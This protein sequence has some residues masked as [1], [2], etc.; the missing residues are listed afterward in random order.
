[1]QAVI[2]VGGKATRLLPLTCNTPKSMV[3]VLNTPFLEHVIT[4]LARHGI[5]EIVLAQGHLAQPIEDYFGDGSRFGVTLSYAVE[6]SPRGTAGAVKNAERYINDTFLVLN[7]DIFTDLDISALLDFHRA[8]R[9][10]I[11]I[12]LTPVDDPTSYGVVETTPEGRVTRFTE[13]PRRAEAK[14][15]MIN[16]GTYVLEPDILARVKEQEPASFEREIFPQALARKEPVFGFASA[17]YWMDIGTPE[18]Y[19]Q[20]HRDLLSGRSA[21]YPALD[22]STAQSSLHPSASIS[23]PVLLGAGC[24]IGRGVKLIG[25]LVLGKGCNVMNDTV[26]EDSVIWQ[27]AWIG[28]HVTIRSSAIANDCHINANCVIEE[29]VVSDNVNIAPG[30]QLKPGTKIEPGTTVD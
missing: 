3:P 18:K 9:A 19:L 11:T 28:G 8:R 24:F 5:S 12:A 10:K 22:A 26:I 17:T 6:D 16:A 21:R 7:G 25:P 13:K 29:A 4:H 23:G 2:L 27:N 1:M 14:S 15:N 30:A 20:L